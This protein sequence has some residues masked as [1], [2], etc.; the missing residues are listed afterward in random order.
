MK[1]LGIERVR[2]LFARNAGYG[3]TEQPVTEVR[4]HKPFTG[5]PDEI[6]V[7]SDRLSNLWRLTRLIGVEEM[8]VLL[9]SADMPRNG[10]NRRV[11]CCPCPR[12]QFFLAKV[13]V[14]RT[15]ES[16][17][18]ALDKR[19]QRRGCNWLGDRGHRERS[20]C[21]CWPL[22]FLV[23]VAKALFPDDLSID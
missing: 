4:I 16:Y 1:D 10:T 17:L 21:G 7:L 5:K 6:S 19:Q 12:D 9:Q 15:F 8:V 18:S 11:L 23:G 20:V 22:I 3:V 13:F 2:Q 14:N